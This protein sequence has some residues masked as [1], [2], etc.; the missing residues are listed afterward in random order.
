[1]LFSPYPV[2]SSLSYSFVVVISCARLF[3]AAV[4]GASRLAAAFELVLLIV[5]APLG[6]LDVSPS[7]LDCPL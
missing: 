3:G 7:T 1:M 5:A 6:S 4:V 2:S